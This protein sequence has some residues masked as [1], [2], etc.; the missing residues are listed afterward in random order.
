MKRNM[1]SE[2]ERKMERRT[3]VTKARTV[4]MFLLIAAVGITSLFPM[5]ANAASEPKKPGQVKRLTVKVKSATSLTIQ[6]KAV[7]GAK[8]YKIYQSTSKNGEYKLVKTLKGGKKVSHTK[9]KL[10][11]GKR[12]YYKVRAY[13]TYKKGK[14]TLRAYGKCSIKKSAVTK[15]KGTSSGKAPSPY[16]AVNLK[17]V[18]ADIAKA[19]KTGKVI[20]KDVVG[21]DGR[22]EYA[23]NVYPY[24]TK[25]H[26]GGTSVGAI[27]KWAE[28]C[29]SVNGVAKGI[30][31][32]ANYSIKIKS[33]ECAAYYTTDGSTPSPTNG[34]KVTKSTGRAKIKAE[35]TGPYGDLQDTLNVKIHFYVKGKLVALDY[36]YGDHEDC[37]H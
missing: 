15:K 1:G 19:E 7:K 28:E 5:E 22:V 20:D 8:G 16:S 26:R 2:E 33:K 10:K 31:H 6:F 23:Y 18:N 27:Y 4:L 17:R 36:F 11:S 37:L 35:H 13:K 29:G 14:K 30:W 34:V 32:G 24:N 25:S 12:Y 9:T 21:K 3:Q